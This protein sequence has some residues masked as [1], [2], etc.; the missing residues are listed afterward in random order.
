MKLNTKAVTSS[1]P[2]QKISSEAKKF[3]STR[4]NNRGGGHCQG[5]GSW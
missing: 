3:L 4:S 5:G 1:K 2:A